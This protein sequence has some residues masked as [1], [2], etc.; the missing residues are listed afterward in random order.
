LAISCTTQPVRQHH[1]AQ[2]L[3]LVNRASFQNIVLEEAYDC[4]QCVN[5]GVVRTAVFIQLNA[6]HTAEFTIQQIY[7]IG[8]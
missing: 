3:D 6:K 2:D 4:E 5:T 1:I 8:E 7:V